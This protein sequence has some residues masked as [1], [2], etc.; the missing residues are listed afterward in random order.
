[1][2]D[3]EYLKKYLSEDALEEGLKK[4]ETGYPVQ[5]IVG[6]VNFYGYKILVNENVLIPRFETELLVD[7][8]INYIKKNFK[9]NIKILDIG[10]G[11]GAIAIALKKVFPLSSV[12]AIDISE[13]ALEVA[14]KNAKINNVQIDFIKS[15]LFENIQDTFDV[16]ISNP[17]YIDYFS[18]I[19]ERVRKYEPALALF[20]DNK[21]LYFY[22]EILRNI[23]KY[24]NEKS[25]IGFEIGETQGKDISTLIEKYL[26][27]SSYSV[28]KDYPG[29]DRF[30]FI[31]TN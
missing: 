24:I 22:E 30:I 17:P 26:P 25:L 29:K 19:D 3:I 13:K 10:T 8:T 31:E 11:S 16:I 2:T 20:A 21:G 15:D 7:K 9:G 6:D 4:L 27:N 23:K 1:M 5:Y 14:K 12:T 18:E 28:Q